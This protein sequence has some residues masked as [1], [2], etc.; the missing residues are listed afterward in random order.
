M[1][2]TPGPWRTGDMF[3]TVF[4]P[5][6]PDGS[7]AEIVATIHKGNRAN[8]RLVAAAPEMADFLDLVAAGNT[9]FN[10]LEEIARKLPAR[11]GGVL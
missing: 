11:I 8:A 9:E 5:K 7:L 1:K 4:G 10:R 3:A 2:T 6:K